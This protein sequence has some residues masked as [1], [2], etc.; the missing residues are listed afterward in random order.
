MET[1]KK[2]FAQILSGVPIEVALKSLDE[3]KESPDDNIEFF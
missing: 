2:I 3:V 1:E